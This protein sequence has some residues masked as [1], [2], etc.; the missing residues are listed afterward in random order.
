MSE[1]A[2]GV[3]AELAQKGFNGMMAMA[4]VAAVAVPPTKPI[5][6]PPSYPFCCGCPEERGT[7]L[8]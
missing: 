4:V 2:N 8:S 1:R 6:R 7:G 3:L 5:M